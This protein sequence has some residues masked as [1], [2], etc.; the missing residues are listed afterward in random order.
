MTLLEKISE[1]KLTVPDSDRIKWLSRSGELLVD[2][3]C[4]DAGLTSS[5]PQYDENGWDRFIEMPPNRILNIYL[6]AQPSS[7]KCLCQ[8]KATDNFSERRLSMTVANFDHLARTVLPAFVIVIDYRGGSEAHSIYFCY[9]GVERIAQTLKRVRELQARGNTFL[10]RHEMT[11]TADSLEAVDFSSK[12]WIKSEIEKCAGGD[13]SNY[14][15]KKSNW[16]KTLGFEKGNYSIKFDRSIDLSDV[17]DAHLGLR[18]FEISG[19]TLSSTRFG[20]EIEEERWAAG[21]VT[22]HAT[23]SG[24]CRVVASSLKKAIRVEA[25]GD[26]FSPCIPELPDCYLKLRIS[27]PYSNLVLE[28]PSGKIKFLFDPDA[29]V[30]LDR[31]IDSLSIIETCMEPDAK[32]EIFRGGDRAATLNI[33]SLIPKDL[34]Y[35]SLLYRLRLTRR[36]MNFVGR[37]ENIAVTA[38]GLVEQEEALKGINMAMNSKVH[39]VIAELADRPD[40]PM[41]GKAG[42]F[43]V[44][45]VVRFSQKTL[46][47]FCAWD[48]RFD[49]RRKVKAT[50]RG[51]KVFGSVLVDDENT[52]LAKSMNEEFK[53]WCR[54]V[55]D[56]VIMQQE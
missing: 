17:V 5:R 11:L 21:Q 38:R 53:A 16:V 4:I 54:S 56:G 3:A 51:C 35:A 26:V 14:T 44:P 18:N 48:G 32:V 33:D 29:E 27:W 20:I 45:V 12:F 40:K 39:K 55:T 31:M 37:R 41:L 36:F 2:Q 19:A 43:A 23:P 22:I 9:F 52:A 25:V 49:I 46:V 28:P 6:D 24:E 15:E 7:I 10:N 42:L 47:A 13:L 50:V 8:V 34:F 30:D 1:F